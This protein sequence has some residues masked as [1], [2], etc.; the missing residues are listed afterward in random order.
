MSEGIR[1]TKTQGAGNDFILVQESEMGME[2]E[3]LARKICDRRFGIGAD[4]LMAASVEGQGVR[5]RYWNADGS[6]AAVCGNGLRCFA[7]YAA[8]SG[9]AGGDTFLVRTDTGDRWVRLCRGTDG[10]ILGVSVGMG[11]PV[12]MPYE[13]PALLPGSRVVERPLEAAGVSLRLSCLR[14]GVPHAVAFWDRDPT[15]EELC[16]IGRAVERHPA[17]PEGINFDIAVPLAED[18]FRIFTWERGAGHTLACGTG[19]CA[20]A[21]AARLCGKSGGDSI[22]LEA[23]GGTLEVECRPGGELVLFG[24]AQLVGEGW[25]FPATES[26]AE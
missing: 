22:R 7:R 9:M 10:A 15:E 19:C 25:F 13:I 18:V 17:F 23:E 3:Q 2:P 21:A 1:F 6:P 26:A 11:R 16:R 4:G 20:V 12:L 8:E 14:V 5:M 24:G